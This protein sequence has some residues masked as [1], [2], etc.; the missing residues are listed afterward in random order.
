MLGLLPPGGGR[1]ASCGARRIIGNGARQMR[2]QNTAKSGFEQG[3]AALGWV[4]QAQ[5]LTMAPQTTTF[6]SVH[7]AADLDGDWS[8]PAAWSNFTLPGSSNN[9]TLSSPHAHTVTHSTGVDQIHL[10]VSTTDTLV[11]TG[12]SLA[13]AT[14]SSIGGGLM[15]YGGTVELMAGV[16]NISS[17]TLA[18]VATLK[19]DGTASL[20]ASGLVTL[21]DGNGNYGII[22]GTG[23]FTTGGAT[24]VTS[25]V[26]GYVDVFVANGATWVNS[27]T[28]SDGGVIGFG[29]GGGAADRISNQGSFF[30]T[31]DLAGTALNGDTATFAN[32]GTLGKTGGTGVSTI[33]AV[34]NNTG[35][36]LV[37][38]GV[39]EAVGGGSIAGTISGLGTFM[40]GAGAFTVNSAV[41]G[42]GTIGLAAPTSVLTATNTASFTGAVT[43]LGTIAVANGKSFTVSGPVTFG[44]GQGN[45]A[46]LSGTGTF[47]TTA[48]VTVT[49]EV[50]GYLDL[51]LAG[52]VTWMNTGS[53]A[54]GGVIYF[55]NGGPAATDTIVN[56]GSFTFSGAQGAAGLN[57]DTAVF[58]N[59]GTLAKSA[60]S[61]AG[62]AALYAVLNST[63]TIAVASGVLQADSGGS[64]A[65]VING[66]GVFS[67]GSGAFT[68]N[69]AVTGS[70]TLG[71]GGTAATLTATNTASFTG[72]LTSLGTIAVAAGKVFTVSG[73]ATFGDGF[74]NAAT[75]SGPGTF[76]TASAVSIAPEVNGYLDLSLAGGVTW[77]NTGNVAA[78]GVTYFGNG[79][80][81]A[82]DLIVN[83]G[84]FTFDGAEGTTA[85]NGDSAIF[86]NSGTLAKSTASGTGTAY[87][88]AVLNSTG[89]VAVAAGALQAN[90]GGA[91]AGVIS[92]AGVFSLGSG[93]FTIGS[94]V[95]GS[96][97]LGLAGAAALLKV[98]SAASFS[99]SV[100]SLGTMSIGTGKSLTLSGAAS[101][102]DGQ[103]SSAVVSG[104]GTLVT[105]GPVTVA[106]EVNGYLDLSLAGGITWLNT[107]NVAVDGLT[108]IGNGGTA[109]TDSIINQGSFSFNGVQATTAQN[110]DSAI[111]TNSGT[112][113]K[114]L[115]SGT[116]TAYLNALLN[117]TG[118]EAVSAGTLQAN[119]GGSIAGVISGAGVFSLG[120]GAFTIASAVTG[121]GT[122]GLVSSA[123]T[124]TVTGNA[125][126][127][128]AVTALGSITITSG[129]SLT[130]SG[131]TTLGDG[132]G[133]LA[134]VS[135]PGTLATTAGVTV[136]AEANQ[137]TD[138]E[139]AHGATWLNT[140]N[141]SIA[142]LINLGAGGTA[143]HDTIINHAIMDFTASQAAIQV[144]GDTASITN[145]GTFAK[146][147]GGGVNSVNA[148]LT[149]SGLVS[150]ASGQLSLIAAVTNTGTLLA[151]STG[152]L[153]LS[154]ATLSNLAGTTLT[155]GTYAADAFS[156]LQLSNG[157][158]VTTDSATIILSGKNATIQS[159]SSSATGQS[160]LD[161][162]LAVISASGS[163]ALRNG[164][165]FNATANGGSFTTAGNLSL[166]GVNFA[167]SKLTVSATGT[168]SGNGTISAVV[169]DSGAIIAA[170]SANGSVLLLNKSVTGTGV[171]GANTGAVLDL[172]AGG[173]LSEAITGAG[174]LQLD[175]ATAFTLA[176]GTI[177]TAA[178]VIDAGAALAGAGLISGATSDNGTLAANGGT[179]LLNGAL[180][181]TG[182]LQA[183]TGAVLAVGA[184]GNFAG[185]VSGAGTL[186]ISGTMPL[187]VSSAAA[188]LGIASV[189]LGS[190]AVL[191]LTGGGAIGTAI[192]GAGS[193]QLDGTYTLAGG[194]I[195]AAATLVDT[196]AALSGF[197]T[198]SGK[199]LD[200]GSITATGG[201]LALSGGVSGTGALI[202]ASGATLDLGGGGTLTEA[203]S[204]AGTLQLDAGTYTLGAGLAVADVAIDAGAVLAGN[205]TI[206]VAVVDNGK[207]AATSGTLVVQSTLAGTGV[208]A[209][210]TG[211][212]L[213]LATPTTLTE[214][215][216]GTGTL[217]LHGAGTFTLGGTLFNITNLV[218]EKGVVLSGAD[219]ITSAISDSG[220]IAANGGK[221]VLKGAITGTGSLQAGTGAVLDLTAG[222]TFAQAI[223]GTGT[224]E[225]G[226]NYTR[227][228]SALS[229]SNIAIDTGAS[230][231]AGGALSSKIVASGTLAVAGSALKLTGALSGKGG[232]LNVGTGAQLELSGGGTFAGALSGAGT[233][234]I[235]KA[236]GLAAGA[237]LSVANLTD[238]ASLTLGASTSL[239]NL[240]ANSVTFAAA[241]GATVKVT[242][243]AGDSITNAG[244]LVENGAG[245]VDLS[246]AVINSGS[247]SASSGTLAF[248]GAATNNGTIT[249]NGGVM[250]FAKALG[251][252]G[253]VNIGAA[254]TLSLLAGSGS[255]QMLDFQAT[256]GLL[257]LSH[258]STFK[259]VIT[260]FGGS[261][262]VDLIGTV[263]NTLSYAGNVLTVSEGA[264]TL[265]S[266]HLTGSYTTANFALSSDGHGGTVISFV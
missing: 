57:G 92:G 196:A 160:S 25:E 64:V 84:S 169:A 56:Q 250:S 107:G 171:L 62:V 74:G 115:A 40:L 139:L 259:G 72:A 120:T 22:S 111:F 254:G 116:G 121:T 88:N 45:G 53:V 105:S 181:G 60:A 143:A 137:Y 226:G 52:G 157:A 67:L 126:F 213:Q 188:S 187:V 101:F 197:G 244:N 223:T 50:N 208:L 212:V 246:V 258:A 202:A 68:I 228:A 218:V 135:G 224:L 97:T 147:A 51:S 221:L 152:T 110:G 179:L 5:A 61:G 241:S 35:T 133:N 131:A 138:L 21:G 162:Q 165:N 12:G 63:G 263:A 195:A 190:G 261:D 38:S 58:T 150:A 155:G 77:L 156:T 164:R 122:L 76:A 175:G 3:A 94:A 134:V 10:L 66:A 29:N 98:T 103:G 257:D 219:T 13:M 44:D 113:A 129:Q 177:A 262:K 247:I 215:V 194:T 2:T 170:S 124:L 15:A 28:V 168:V 201:V 231:T 266:L 87:L 82:T 104:L 16:S 239:T 70:G 225:L 128:G 36:I 79:S 109:A 255:G 184:G 217:D 173:T 71:L 11:M 140:G 42:S 233:V 249:A 108:Y 132:L 230:L 141:V 100:S 238:T 235:D 242:G 37:S 127:T 167:A 136:S 85:Q 89:T 102:G 43:S 83:Q 253:T 178:T 93:T 151:T 161:S 227:G 20:T 86:T 252:T 106:P 26:N 229:V 4:P 240:A 159:L 80:P 234:L 236:L 206:S 245:V 73:A 65:G 198:L 144:N 118:T 19:L 78:D 130:L 251:G 23:V 149:N 96:G 69:S 264:K 210:G 114:T 214:A 31:N 204:G 186:A 256:T 146:T 24:A 47:A 142:G 191:D 39:L 180:T 189:S 260:G 55:G 8:N 6:T 34:L 220:I 112:L 81:V 172:S 17:L 46:T 119:G 174:T 9:V 1:A 123:T 153:D 33:N 166:D 7:W 211:A 207:L 192:S 205:G 193:L 199:T 209:A 99:G 200:Q 14:G 117:T 49:P 185:S 265:A 232:A 75:L 145:T 243:A 91:I 30:L 90:D 203:I 32:S 237:S 148:A 48:G 18:N 182:S 248:L 154:S 41:L 222:G 176:G 158:T 59:T 163:L 54:V 216:G 125:S 183:G 27:G 95:T